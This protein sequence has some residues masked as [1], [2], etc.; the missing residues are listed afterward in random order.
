ML[1]KDNHTLHNYAMRSAARTRTA[2]RDTI[3]MPIDAQAAEFFCEQMEDPDNRVCCDSGAGEATWASISH[4]IYLSISA[5]GVH[6][7]LG[8]SSSFVQSTV[9]DSWKPEHLRMM[10]LGG[11]RRFSEFMAEQGVPLDMPIRD[12]YRT[13]AAKWYRENLLALAEGSEPLEPLPKGTGHLPMDFGCSPAQCH[14]DKVFAESPKKGS[15]TSGGVKHD[16][17]VRIRDNQDCKDALT[18]SRQLSIC[19][20]L[21]ACF[22]WHSCPVGVQISSQS[23][24][25]D[26]SD[27]SEDS[28]ATGLYPKL[29]PCETPLV[30]SLSALLGL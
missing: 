11:N 23:D 1:K 29:D 20:Q 26:D 30:K 12:K 9:M 16:R 2:M 22:R 19:Q 8:V 4:G 6:R 21:V 15:M 10:E 18:K 28:A 5:A 17:V 13:R 3:E 14:L 7:S 24:D 25:P 27:D